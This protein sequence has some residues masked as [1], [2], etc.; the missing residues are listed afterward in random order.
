MGKLCILTGEETCPVFKKMCLNC[1]FASSEDGESFV[2]NNEDNKAAAI[3]KIK[4]SIPES[5]GL[6]SLELAPRPLKNP[7]KKCPKWNLNKKAVWDAVQEG[8]AE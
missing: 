5:Y 2:C 1:E 8:F 4:E 6:V 7:T 3:E